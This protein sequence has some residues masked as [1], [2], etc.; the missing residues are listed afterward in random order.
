MSNHTTSFPTQLLPSKSA[1]KYA[2]YFLGLVV[3][4]L[5]F[6]TYL[7]WETNRSTTINRQD[8]DVHSVYRHLHRIRPTPLWY[9]I[10]NDTRL[11]H[12]AHFEDRYFAYKSPAAIVLMLFH[13]HLSP[14]HSLYLKVKIVNESGR[15]REACIKGEWINFGKVVQVLLEVDFFYMVIFK[16]RQNT[17]IPNYIDIYDT[18]HCNGSPIVQDMP[19]HYKEDEK[20]IEFATCLYKGISPDKTII[21]P[22]I[23]SW[24]EVNRAIGSQHVTIYDQDLAPDMIEMIQK[25]V[26][27]GFVELI[28]WRLYNP[29]LRIANYGQLATIQD[30][31]YR[32]LRRAQ[33]IVFIDLDELI[34]P[35]KH[36]TLSKMMSHLN[37]RQ[38]NV[39][40][41]R[42]Y[43]SFWHNVGKPVLGAKKYTTVK[44]KLPV[45]FRRTNRTKNCPPT[46]RYKNI[47]KVRTAVRVGIHHVFQMKE[48]E[49][50][51][52]V[53]EEIG[54]MH[55]YRTPDYAFEEEQVEDMV[56]AKYANQVM[57]RLKSL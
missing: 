48:G 52:Q 1:I 37:E 4:L 50:V 46:I 21:T 2:V 36:A 29:D 45:H 57:L 7:H 55:H 43:N 13:Y 41:Y 27:E 33:Y 14:E 5:A 44:L 11:W 8:E 6:A 3:L 39:T 15:V 47:V 28:T 51:Y 34:I 20:Q 24:I 32:Y 25:Y 42:F 26:K 54:L 17:I 9:N 19:L 38:T 30:C 56:M 53:P 22:D 18:P 16:L 23:A 35:H 49:T 12:L 10:S 31:L 40:Q